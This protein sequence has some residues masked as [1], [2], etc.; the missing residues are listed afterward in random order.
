M[1]FN[2]IDFCVLVVTVAQP[3]QGARKHK[4]CHPEPEIYC[5]GERDVKASVSA[6]LTAVC[7]PQRQLLVLFF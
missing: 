6:I 7:Q 3:L 1:A 2:V 5:G 4:H